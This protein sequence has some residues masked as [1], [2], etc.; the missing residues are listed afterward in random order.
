MTVWDEKLS[1]LADQA[2]STVASIT[3]GQFISIR[4]GVLTYQ[5]A[6]I[7]GNKM[8]V[9]ILDHIIENAFYEG[10]FDPDTPASPSCYAFG[11]TLAECRP[12]PDCSRPQ[13]GPGGGCI[14]CPSNQF[15]TSDRGRGKACGNRQRLAMITEG[16]LKDVVGAEVAYLRIPP[17]N[18]KVWAGYVR[19]LADSFRRPPLLAVTELSV[20][21]DPKNQVGIS[22]KT[23][24]IIDDGDLVG[25]LLAKHEV[26]SKEIFFPYPKMNEATTAAPPPPVTKGGKKAYK[27]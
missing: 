21:P 9:I 5:G 6:A 2:K 7:T 15:G 16:D 17:T 13:G 4:S 1:Q 23:N 25:E 10:D 26:V 22:Y 20:H 27:R 19:S 24:R 3:G 8:S 14:G 12:H 11:R 18:L